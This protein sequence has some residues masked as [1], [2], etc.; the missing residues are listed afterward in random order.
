MLGRMKLYNAKPKAS[1]YRT[2]KC[3]DCVHPDKRLAVIKMAGSIVNFGNAIESNTRYT[4][5]Q[6]EH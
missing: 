1:K 3:T 5:S 4:V 6:T 2:D